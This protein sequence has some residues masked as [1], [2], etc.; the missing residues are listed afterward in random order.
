MEEDLIS[1]LS[2]ESDG[3]LEENTVPL[4][5]QA[6][7][8]SELESESTEF[9][10]VLENFDE[11]KF[12]IYLNESEETEVIIT[13]QN[14]NGPH[15]PVDGTECEDGESKEVE[16]ATTSA[17]SDEVQNSVDRIEFMDDEFMDF[18]VDVIL[19][20]GDE[21]QLPA[22]ENMFVDDGS[23]AGALSKKGAEDIGNI[24]I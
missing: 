22:N 6:I 14:H 24:K 15:L 2:Y 16:M 8:Y 11:P 7:D 4:D 17:R 1:L 18:E 10:K 13:S 20:I 5:S 12:P 9:E 21:L 3:S 19:E 23:N